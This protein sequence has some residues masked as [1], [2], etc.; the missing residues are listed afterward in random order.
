MHIKERQKPAS[1]GKTQTAGAAQAGKEETLPVLDDSLPG[2]QTASEPPGPPNRR[3]LLVDDDP[4]FLNLLKEVLSHE[5]FQVQTAATGKEGFRLAMEEAPAL[6]LLDVNLADI[7]GLELA[8]QLQEETLVPFMFLS[9]HGEMEIV[10]EATR[11][12]AVGYLVKPVNHEQILPA[13]EAALARSAEISDLRKQQTN[14]TNALQTGRETSMAVG[15][16]MA[17]HQVDHGLAFDVLRDFSRASRRKI[18]EVAHDILAA[19]RL[20]NGFIPLFAAR[21]KNPGKTKN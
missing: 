9:K 5:G 6:A 18:A 8:K 11:H 20:L 21:N 15:I 7:S 14:L 16:L 10:R 13:V 12:G 4:D 1:G 3:I 2:E 17:K 19:E